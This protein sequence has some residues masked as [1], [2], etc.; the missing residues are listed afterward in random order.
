MEHKPMQLVLFEYAL[1]HLI[2]VHRIIRLP[3]GNALLIGVGGSGKQSMTKLAAYCA[4]YDVF[5]IALSRGYGENEFREDLK[6]LYK[7]L[8][9]K[10]SDKPEGKELILIIVCLI[11]NSLSLH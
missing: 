1:E 4:G 2:R 7:S 8:G 10:V 11:G 6:E 5:E 3:R 9:S